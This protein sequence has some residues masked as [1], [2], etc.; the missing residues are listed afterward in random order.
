[1]AI[2]IVQMKDENGENI[3]P[4]SLFTLQGTTGW[5][6]DSNV[7]LEALNSIS[8]SVVPSKNEHS[9]SNGEVYTSGPAYAY[10]LHKYTNSFYSGLLF[11]YGNNCVF[12]SFTNGNYRFTRFI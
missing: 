4:K 9:I 10:V 12:F 1:M 11:N 2:K 6:T 5:S 7:V 3:F 8:T